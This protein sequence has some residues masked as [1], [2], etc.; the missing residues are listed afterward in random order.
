[1]ADDGHYLVIKTK[2]NND[3]LFGKDRAPMTIFEVKRVLSE[4]SVPAN[5]RVDPEA[6]EAADKMGLMFA[7]T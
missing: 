1:M 2:L 6:A 4:F 7:E 3:F 5:S